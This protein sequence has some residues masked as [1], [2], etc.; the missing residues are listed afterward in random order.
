MGRVRGQGLRMAGVLAA[1]LLFSVAGCQSGDPD[2]QTFEQVDSEDPW[3]TPDSG[4]SDQDE[5]S[6][7]ALHL[8]VLAEPYLYPSLSELE[9][10]GLLVIAYAVCN[11]LDDGR[12]PL[13]LSGWLENNGAGSQE[14][15][16]FVGASVGILCPEH[17]R[18]LVGSFS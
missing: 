6:A 2:A 17:Q 16:A 3:V 9:P 11:G 7:R 10:E 5:I 8:N 1:A 13:D 14:A 4:L 18:A 15:S 12:H